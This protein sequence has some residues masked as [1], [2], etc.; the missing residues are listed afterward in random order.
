MAYG[1]FNERDASSVI[2]QIAS[3]LA[4]CHD[5]GVVHRDIKPENVLVVDQDS[6]DDSGSDSGEAPQA[7]D[8]VI[9]LIDFGF[10][11]RILRG[12][13]LRAKVGTFLYTAP[14]ALKGDPCDEKVDEWALGCML[15][16]MLSG[17]SPFF[18][19][20]TKERIIN[21]TYSFEAP[22]WS[23]ISDSAKDL[24]QRLLVV[25]PVKRISAAEMLHTHP[26]FAVGTPASLLTKSSLVNAIGSIK[27]F[28]EQNSLRH[29]CTGVLARQLDESRLHEL[30]ETFTQ[31]DTD[32]NGILSVSELKKVC[33]DFGLNEPDEFQMLF[34]DV[35]MNGSGEIDYTEFI[36]ACIDKRIKQQE[37]SCWAAFRV[38]DLDGNGKITHQELHAVV[39]SADMSGAFS[40]DTLEQIWRE[41]TG[42]EL[43][44]SPQE[45]LDGQVDFDQFLA[46]LGSVETA[47]IRAA[48]PAEASA[49]ED[50]PA[51]ASRGLPILGRRGVS[52][53]GGG[54]P[55]ASKAALPIG[56]KAT[57]AASG[58]L[59]IAGRG[60]GYPNASGG[61]LPIATRHA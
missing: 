20:N 11:C 46:A 34:A 13:K 15:F 42:E 10:G 26:W 59:P 1:N 38:F 27:S 29:L 40:Q 45:H 55:I 56:K 25:D 24:V 23:G 7:K 32:E 50:K 37:D 22:E 19:A 48:K 30:H 52:V 53:P 5:H 35:D 58:G 39:K 44:D 6:G 12:A 43:S 33:E 57:P 14:E 49:S 17:N 9:K 54:L 18:G 36:A 31:L 21:G 51:S 60:G 28:H 61:G 47:R 8:I 16:A 4:Y 2:R 41:L 3:A